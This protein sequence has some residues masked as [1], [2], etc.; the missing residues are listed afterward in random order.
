[1][2]RLRR[3]VLLITNTSGVLVSLYSLIHTERLNNYV[4]QKELFCDL[5]R[6]ISCS[7]TYISDY[8]FLFNI[9][10][11]FLALL[12]FWFVFIKPSIKQ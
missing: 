5:S 1:M 4:F 3:I 8:S 7:S 6:V 12:F 10:I 9:P 2:T 11:S